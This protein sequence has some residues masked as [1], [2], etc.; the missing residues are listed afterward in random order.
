MKFI[1]SL[2]GP[3]WKAIS[4]SLVS[5]VIII[6]GFTFY[7]VQDLAALRNLEQ[8][9]PALSTQVYAK[10]GTLVHQYFTHN[11]VNVDYSKF[12]VSLV[13]ALIAT[14]D[15]SF[16][17]HWGISARGM[18][19]AVIVDILQMRFAQGFSTITMQLARNLYNEI[20][21]QKSI[22]RK[23][24][25]IITAIEIERH[26]SKEEIIE[27]YLNV[28]FFGHSYYGIQS[29][30]NN[31]FDKEVNEL[32]T[33][34]SSLLI[35]LLQSP[36]NYSPFRNPDRAIVRR[37]IVLQRLATVGYISQESCDTLK[38]IPLEVQKKEEI[39]FAPYFTEHLRQQLNALQDSLKVNI[40]KDG[41]KIYTTLDMQIQSVMDSAIVRQMDKVQER[42]RAQ[43]KLIRL[44][45]TFATDTS[46][47]TND[48]L[49]LE[50]TLV[51]IGMVALNPKTG[52]ILAMVGG[53]DFDK[54]KFNH[55][56]QAPRQ[57]GS[58]FKPFLYT[59]AIENGYTPVH[60]E[61]NQP[62]VLTNDDGTRWTPENYDKSV[63]GP[64][65][66]R[67]GLRRSLN[68]VAIRLIQRVGPRNVVNTARRF[69][70]TTRLRAVPALALGTSEVY[71]LQ[72]VSAF[73]V[74]ANHGIRVTPFSILRIED[75]FGSVIYETQAKREEVLRESTTYMM[76]HLLQ[77]VVN[78]GTGVRLRSQFHIPYGV[79]IG[80]KTGTTADFTDAW[81][82]S[83]TPDV[84]VGTWVGLDDPEIKLGNGM[85]G[86][87]AALPF[88][89]DFLK[90]V[91]DSS[92][93]RPAK[94]PFPENDIVKHLICK[95]SYKI[96]N[97]FCPDIY[98]EDFDIR[99]QP[100]ET[101]DIHKKSMTGRKRPKRGF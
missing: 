95:E 18:A 89:G 88:V 6:I 23:I 92:F 93:F 81:F 86:A 100:K 97:N 35:G 68:L 61:L 25:E 24:R 73:S 70:L 7:L 36:N 22:V 38:Q 63:G 10:D 8:A 16:W 55:A 57:P 9:K 101:C 43:G 59:T 90:S 50:K 82:L 91:Y 3:S 12:P 26:Y 41:L 32:S 11:R 40:Y 64:T 96:A 77:N 56:T 49:F 60:T 29:A 21:S 65:S 19:R 33:E 45:K 72:L 94:F 80:G 87:T 13:Q 71:L 79:E 17:D 51:Q 76:N 62:V 66:L 34:E 48:S 27:M 58:A 20:G 84:T 54:Y 4:I 44:R 14:E 74:F 75:R 30:S 37:N 67:D 28:S 47:H 85:S 5:I 98:E 52:E 39:N 31:Y 2:K 15:A 69:G 83:F 1:T 46:E 42:V 78:M 53:R 99:F